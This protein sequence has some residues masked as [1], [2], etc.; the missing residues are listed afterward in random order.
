MAEIDTD[1]KQMLLESESLTV[2]MWKEDGL[3]YVFDPKARDPAGHTY[4][5]DEWSVLPAPEVES[6]A[7]SDEGRSEEGKGDDAK[8]TEADEDGGGD[9]SERPTHFKDNS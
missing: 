3:F 2:V 6:S 4:G 7:H 9:T 8:D 5:K 1:K